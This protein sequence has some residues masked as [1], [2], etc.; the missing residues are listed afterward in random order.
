MPKQALEIPEYTTQIEHNS[1]TVLKTLTVFQQ[2]INSLGFQAVEFPPSPA[3][4]PPHFSKIAVEVKASVPAHAL[5]LWLGVSKGR[6]PVKYFHSNK[7]SF[8]VS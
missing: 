7:S 6:L 5:R 8:C 4:L 2:D 3:S 1:Q